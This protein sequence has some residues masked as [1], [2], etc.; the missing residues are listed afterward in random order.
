MVGGVKAKILLVMSILSVLT[1]ASIGIG[2]LTFQSLDTQVSTVTDE[3][4]PEIGA[5]TQLIVSTGELTG[6]LLVMSNATDTK[7]LS[8]IRDQID[9]QIGVLG[10]RIAALD[11]ET[12]RDFAPV[13]MAVTADIAA[14]DLARKNE[15][16]AQAEIAEAIDALV[17]SG[18]AASRRIAPLV[19]DAYLD[20][21]SGGEATIGAVET[22]L[23]T[24][25][26]VRFSAVSD[27]ML[28]KSEVNLLSGMALA[29]TAI[30]DA[31]TVSIINDVGRASAETLQD[32]LPRLAEHGDLADY[33]PQFAAAAELYVDVFVNGK[34]VNAAMRQEFLSARQS[35][36]SAFAAALDDLVFGLSI[37][38]ADASDANRSEIQAL[39]DTQVSAIRQL[40]S[41]EI[42][43]REFT[44]VAL[45][46]ALADDAAT[47]RD[48]RGSVHSAATDLQSAMIIDDTRLQKLVDEL[49]E[50]ANDETGI[51]ARREAMLA[52]Q[53]RSLVLTA[54]ATASVGEI[55]G[56]AGEYGNTSLTRV[57][58]AGTI[59]SKQIVNAEVQ[60][61][62]VAGF[63]VVV[64]L[65]SILLVQR[66]LIRPLGELTAA[67]E[68]LAKGDM[69]PIEGFD[70]RGDEIGRMG[71]AL[72]VFRDNS[73]KVE[74]LNK[75][76]E[77]RELKEKEARQ[78]M[79]RLLA[80]EI[81]SVVAAASVGEFSRRVDSQF[82]DPE[83]AQLGE[84][85]NKLL[86]ATD[87]GLSGT[88]AALKAMADADL[89]HR[90]SDDFQ[91]V[92]AELANDVN[93]TAA[94]LSD[95]IG[96]MRGSAESS[97]QQANQF[98]EGA[99]QLA[100][101]A[102]Q[103]AATLE[104]TASAMEEMAQ[105]VKASSTSLI[106]AEQLSN[107][108]AKKTETG[109]AAASTAVENVELIQESSS[110]IYDI[111]SVIENISFQTNLLALNAAVEAAR[112][113]DAGKGFA[114]VAS[115][116][117]ALAQRSTEAASEIS[118]LI[119]ESTERVDLG[120]TSVEAARES[121][122]EIDTSVR[123][124]IELLARLAESSREQAAGI[125]EVSQAVNRMDE[126]TQE[127]AGLADLSGSMS[128]ELSKQIS[129]LEE[130]AASFKIGGVDQSDIY[131]APDSA[132]TAPADSV[133]V[134]GNAG[135]IATPVEAGTFDEEE[136]DKEFLNI[137]GEFA[138][139]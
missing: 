129:K 106:E 92:F 137:A 125:G 86:I 101:R 100:S 27:V 94:Q 112:A 134:T 4:V 15:F 96:N 71:Q 89:T 97:S 62:A 37:D 35:A 14:L 118:E 136:S 31:G 124:V 3:R 55:A 67:T 18:N 70:S 12:R 2:F 79:F 104:E 68:R 51:V 17:K 52:A 132:V 66:T 8:R 113:G 121:F 85:L 21:R 131:T 130:M 36:D 46:A 87:N 117:R 34:P 22:T 64:L 30:S 50:V 56:L 65:L 19:E 73:L 7:S 1:L 28:A 98:T 93:G 45:A 120:V 84:D 114:V 38:A 63:S 6:N 32:I 23:T 5:A 54:D 123:P 83:I 26:D 25:V 81:G 127:N 40:L 16:A 13:L 10:K 138:N 135:N 33:Y 49:S 72:S 57:T 80:D 39:L 20:L 24:L 9:A 76:N 78:A 75:D 111:I 126:M 119:R 139:F 43:L 77:A 48:A 103:Q 102:E 91:G 69:D 61:L 95:L 41:L 122:Q 116:V 110:K 59:V 115:E 128:I 29:R 88:R 108:V 105:T 99:Q 109:T 74:Q 90:M 47:L 60:M 58:D 107:E 11:E 53:E 82:D 44:Y 42:D 133:D